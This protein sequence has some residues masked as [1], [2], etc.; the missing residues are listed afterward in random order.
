MVEGFVTNTMLTVVLRLVVEGFVTNTMLTV[1]L[2][3]M[4]EGFCYKDQVNSG[5]KTHG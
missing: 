1:V 4:V 3:L 5:F 2:R